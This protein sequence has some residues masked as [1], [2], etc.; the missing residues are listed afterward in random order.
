MTPAPYLH[1]DDEHDAHGDV[2][3]EE[4]IATPEEHPSAKIQT[5]LRQNGSREREQR[6]P[7]A[8]SDR[9]LVVPRHIDA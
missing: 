5:N 4:Y 3:R 2:G 8:H 6:E 1:E 7:E 9:Q